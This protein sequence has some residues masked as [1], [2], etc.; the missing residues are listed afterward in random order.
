MQ[1]WRNCFSGRRAVQARRK[2]IQNFKGRLRGFL[3]IFQHRRKKSNRRGHQHSSHTFPFFIQRVAL[4]LPSFSG[5]LGRRIFCSTWNKVL[6]RN[7]VNLIPLS[8]HILSFIETN[9]RGCASNTL[10]R[11]EGYEFCLTNC[12]LSLLFQRRR[13]LDNQPG[14]FGKG[15]KEKKKAKKS[16]PISNR[17]LRRCWKIKRKVLSDQLT[18]VFFLRSCAILQME[19]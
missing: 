1:S 9:L 19:M 16:H 5:K 13:D 2:T 12:A 15:L 8:T 17:C 4:G 10:P 7:T 14:A 11:K 3:L 6:A 18:R